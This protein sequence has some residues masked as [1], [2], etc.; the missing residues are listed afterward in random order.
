LLEP[1]RQP[2]IEL[3]IVDTDEHVGPAR[4][5]LR[6]QPGTQAQQPR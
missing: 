4:G 3:L 5:D 1:P 2:K 6:G